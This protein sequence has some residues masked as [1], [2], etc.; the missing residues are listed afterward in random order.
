MLRGHRKITDKPWI[1]YNHLWIDIFFK[2]VLD[3]EGGMGPVLSEI[4]IKYLFENVS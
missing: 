3:M 4:L 2:T 1:S